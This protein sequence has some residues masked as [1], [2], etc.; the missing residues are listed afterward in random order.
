MSSSVTVEDER[1]WE[2]DEAGTLNGVRIKGREVSDAP[3]CMVN[4]MGA[5]RVREIGAV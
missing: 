3:G 1:P 4:A 5:A 2:G